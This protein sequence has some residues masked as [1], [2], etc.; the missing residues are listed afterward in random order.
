M[1]MK[2]KHPFLKLAKVKNEEEFYKKYPDETSF[3]KDFP[4]AQYGYTLDND[5]IPTLEESGALGYVT[6]QQ[7]AVPVANTSSPKSSGGGGKN[8]TGT[9]QAVAQGAG[10]VIDLIGGVQRAIAVGA[11]Q[12][13]NALI[14]DNQNERVR[15]PQVGY[16]QYAYGTGSQMMYENGG[17]VFTPTPTSIS[18]EEAKMRQQEAIPYQIS[19]VISSQMLNPL[20][21]ESANIPQSTP[22]NLFNPRAMN[23]QDV[24]PSTNSNEGKI[25]L[26]IQEYIYDDKGRNTQK[27]KDV[28]TL[29]FKD[30]KEKDDYLKQRNKDKGYGLWFAGDQSRSVAIDT[31]QGNPK[32]MENGGYIQN[33]VYELDPQEIKR[34]QQLGYKIETL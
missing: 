32:Y 3:F 4:Q 19:D 5:G 13:L 27:T 29:W 20:Y 26:T 30:V 15:T 18:P 7:E 28:E 34:L 22:F 8:T 16:N 11:P 23:W 1:N 24:Q 25:P 10:E 31:K 14:P 2:N 17:N 21:P 33:E 6:P 12:L 9:I